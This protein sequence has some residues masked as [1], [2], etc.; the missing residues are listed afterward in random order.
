MVQDWCMYRNQNLPYHCVYFDQRF[1]F[2]R[3][4]HDR[5]LAKLSAIGIASRTVEW[6][7]AS[8]RDRRFSVK[9]NDTLSPPLP[10][11]SGVPQGS[12]SAPLLHAL[13]VLD[14]NR[15]LPEGVEYLVFCDDLKIYCPILSENSYALL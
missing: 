5:L 1:A 12:C 9:I 8:L 10:A 7:R 13:Y 6:C 14:L 3:V 15:Y 11:P 2:D 4:P